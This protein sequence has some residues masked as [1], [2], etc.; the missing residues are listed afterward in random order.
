MK[1]ATFRPMR[2]AIVI[3]LLATLAFACGGRDKYEVYLEGLQVEAEA[4]K[5]PCALHTEQGQAAPVLSGDQVQT[6]LRRTEDAIALYEEAGRLGLNDVDY[7]RV[8]SRALQR[9]DRLKDMLTNVRAMERG[10]L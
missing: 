1:V 4:E 5:G 7:N 3:S 9:R 6:C 8:Y 2:S 10:A